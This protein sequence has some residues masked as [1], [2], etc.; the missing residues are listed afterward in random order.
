MIVKRFKDEGTFF[1]P[2]VFELK[3]NR[4]NCEREKVGAE[5][6]RKDE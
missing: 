4:A 5:T 1:E 6:E 3:R 2:K